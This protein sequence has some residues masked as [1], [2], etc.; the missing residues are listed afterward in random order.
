MGGVGIYI[1]NSV[2]YIIKEKSA[3]STVNNNNIDYIV[4]QFIGNT[5]IAFAC[6]YCLDKKLNNIISIIEHIKSLLHPTTSLIIDGDFNINLLDVTTDL[7]IDFFNN[8]HTYSLHPVITL[9]TRVT[10][11]TSTLIDNFSCV[12]SL[13]PLCSRV[14]K[15]DISD[16]YLIELSLNLPSSSNTAIKRNFSVKI[17]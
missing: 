11:T 4:I 6:M 15:T 12:I 7:A 1:H 16:H 14:I 8:L 9:P 2:K 10:K 3:D 17:N 13:L 5:N